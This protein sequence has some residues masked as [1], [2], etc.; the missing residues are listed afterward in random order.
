MRAHPWT[1]VVSIFCATIYSGCATRAPGP[2]VPPPSSP[3]GRGGPGS[4]NIGPAPE[5][6]GR[7]R[8][9]LD[10]DWASEPRSPRADLERFLVAATGQ[11][12]VTRSAG[13]GID[14]GVASGWEEE[15]GDAGGSEWRFEIDPAASWPDGMPVRAVDVVR[16]WE[17]ALR[18]GSSAIW[19]L[20]PL[21]GG[22]AFARGEAESVDGLRAE[23]G[24]VVVR[25]DRPTPD[26]LERLTHPSLVV[27]RNGGDPALRG[28]GP[29]RVMPGERALVAVPGRALLERVDSVSASTADARLLARLREVDVAI[30]YGRDASEFLEA[31]EPSDVERFAIERLE[32]WDR[33]YYLT[34]DR[35]LRWTRDPAFRRWLSGTI[36]RTAMMRYLFDGL[37]GWPCD[38]LAHCGEAITPPENRGPQW[39][40]PSGVHP[41][42][43]LAFDERDRMASAIA[44]RI[45]ADLAGAGVG[46]DLAPRAREEIERG[47]AGGPFQALLTFRRSWTADPVLTLLEIFNALGPEQDDFGTALVAAAREPLGSARRAAAALE[48]QERVLREATVVPL[49]RVDAWIVTS[50]GLALDPGASPSLE[51]AR[52]GWRP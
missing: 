34:L 11:G 49:A 39:R 43:A 37:G 23:E 19:L 22:P 14:S 48:I 42:I 51:I 17:T 27:W 30:V 28:S 3:E 20:E 9:R 47:A 38:L 13:G 26:L 52:A 2:A 10:G 29:F 1:L 44:A 36:D 31:S 8:I 6:G 18:M 33:V 21:A 16:S 25:L 5:P 12:L 24:A 45:K 35:S 50:P 41:R 4:P 40:V 15:G 46:V 32:A 7:V